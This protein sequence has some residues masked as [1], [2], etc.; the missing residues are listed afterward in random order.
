YCPFVAGR[1][2]GPSCLVIVR[3]QNE[4]SIVIQLHCSLISFSFLSASGG[5]C[6]VRP[7]L[8]ILGAFCWPVITAFR[9]CSCVC[10]CDCG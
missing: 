1:G 6:H 9:V 4:Y 8:S 7:S 10:Y 5:S 3:V 2:G